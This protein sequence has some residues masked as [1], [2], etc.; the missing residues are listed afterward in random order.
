MTNTPNPSVLQRL[1]ERRITQRFRNFFDQNLLPAMI[2]AYI[3]GF[4]SGKVPTGMGAS[5]VVAE[6]FRLGNRD[7][8]NDTSPHVD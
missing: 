5:N 1:A 8:V 2:A 7:R 4:T 6:A 3:E